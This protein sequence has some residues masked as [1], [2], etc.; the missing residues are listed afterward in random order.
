MAMIMRTGLFSVFLLL[1]GQFFLHDPVSDNV[2]PEPDGDRADSVIRI[3]ISA[4]G[5]LMC[6]STQFN[7]ARVQKDSFDFIP[8]FAEVK[9]LLNRADLMLGNLE[10]TFGGSSLPYSGYPQ[11]N[12]PDAYAY[13]IAQAGFDFLVTANN[14]ANDTG[15]KG[16]LRTDSVLDAAGIGHTGTFH[17]QADHDSI[18]ILDVKGIRIAVL[19]YTFSTNGLDIPAGKPFLVNYIDSAAI[20]SDIRSARAARADL[21]LVFFHFGEEYHRE[22]TGYQK[23]YVQYAI[24]C[25]ADIVLGSHPHVIEPAF[26]YKTASGARLDSGFAIYSMG[27]FL[28]N[29]KD[30]YTD[31]GLILNLHLAENTQNKE[32]RLTSVDYVPTW[33]YRGTHADK[34]LHIVFPVAQDPGESALPGFLD[35][36]DLV[37]MREAYRHTE[38]ILQSMGASVHPVK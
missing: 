32:I 27:N 1:G 21:V 28:S 36:A 14:H 24:D 22:P 6:H 35:S 9:P 12:C 26:F 15:E 34:K 25:G 37:S 31:E 3:T 18:R 7:Y 4:V 20:F 19:A 33:V 38:D 2:H 10:T 16:I 13:A 29:Q 17:S 30:I 5:D 8:C 11:F 23:E